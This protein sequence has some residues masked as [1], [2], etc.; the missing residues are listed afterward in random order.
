MSLTHERLLAALDYS[1]S[2]GEFTWK[3]ST[4]RV[5]R[6]DAAKTLDRDGYIRIQL[7]G[8]RYFAHRLA[9]FYVYKKFPE[10]ETD[11]I[12]RI[13]TDN[14]MENLREADRKM[15][16]KNRGKFKWSKHLKPD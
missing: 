8:I 9:W 3:I 6:G 16:T 10:P 12:N 7:D 15:N 14:R 2:T 13:K 5:K 1:A 11:H 4:G